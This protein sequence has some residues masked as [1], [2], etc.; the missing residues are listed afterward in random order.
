MLILSFIQTCLINSIMHEHSCE[1]RYL[2][3]SHLLSDLLFGIC[4][5]GAGL[6]PGEII[7]DLNED[8]LNQLELEIVSL[9]KTGFTWQDPYTQ[10][11]IQ[12]LILSFVIKLPFQRKTCS[13]LVLDFSDPVQAQIG[14]TLGGL[15]QKTLQAI[16]NQEYPT[17]NL[18]PTSTKRDEIIRVHKYFDKSTGI[19]KRKFFPSSTSK[20]Y[21][22]YYPFDDVVDF[23]PR[24]IPQN[25]ASAN[26]PS[27]NGGWENSGI[28]LD[29]IRLAYQILQVRDREL[30]R[31]QE[32][33]GSKLAELLELKGFPVEEPGQND[34]NPDLGLTSDLQPVYEA[35]GERQPGYNWMDDTLLDKPLEE[36]GMC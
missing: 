22:D 19:N 30:K 9:V 21:L 16:E 3:L 31:E 35:E 7:F 34:L 23:Y 36:N 27:A 18:L 26:I 12:N 5:N 4:D 32:R 29:D 28:P 10:C 8:A 11:T 17:V 2:I 1:I 14:D 25:Y 6:K 33:Y 24:E 20:N 13:G 15:Y